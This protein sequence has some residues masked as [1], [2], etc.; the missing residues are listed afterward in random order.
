MDNT[1]SHNA[2]LGTRTADNLMNAF[3]YERRKRRAKVISMAFTAAA[4]CVAI[5][6]TVFVEPDI[7]KELERQYTRLAEMENEILTIVETE[8][9]EETDMIM[10]ILRTISADAIPLEDQLP[11]ELST[12]EKSRILNEYY[13][14]KYSALEN[15]MAN[16]SR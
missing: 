15:L 13:D 8:Y 7:S 4:A 3:R 2:L 11:E 16:I 12:K 1:M 6:M 9:P 5:L 10:N 14:L